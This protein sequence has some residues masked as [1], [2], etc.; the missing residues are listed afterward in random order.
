MVSEEGHT[1]TIR[2]R[3]KTI[4]SLLIEALT[5]TNVEIAWLIPTFWPDT[6]D[7]RETRNCLLF[8]DLVLSVYA[9]FLPAAK[10]WQVYVYSTVKAGE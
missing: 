2:G 10:Q 9:R 1:K 6:N 8:L 7:K 4:F 5:Y 3:S